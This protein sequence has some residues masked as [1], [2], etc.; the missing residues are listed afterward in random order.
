MAI[1]FVD[2]VLTAVLHA[3]GMIQ[4]LNPFMKVFIERSEWLFAG[5]KAVTLVA[6]WIALVSY[7]KVNLTFVRQASLAGAGLY[8]SIW[9]I[10]FLVGS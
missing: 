1:G 9:V 10:W 6:A 5:V 4:E 2:L 7:A 8:M 3:N